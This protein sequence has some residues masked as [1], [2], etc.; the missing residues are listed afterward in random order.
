V[1][2]DYV[3]ISGASRTGSTLLLKILNSNPDIA[4]CRENYFLGHQ[5][6]REGIRYAI[7]RNVGD[8]I[9]EASV[10]QLV[11]FMY[12]GEFKRS[13]QT[14]W[15]WLRAKTDRETFLQKMLAA[16]VRDDRTIFATM[17]EIHGDWLQQRKGLAKS[18]PVLGEKTPSHIYYVPT[19]LQWFPNSRVIHTFRDPRG[20]FASE[21]RVRRQ[22]PLSFPYKKLSRVGPALFGFV[23]LQVTYAWSRAARLHT[24]YKRLY[25]DSYRLL[26]FEDLVTTPRKSIERLC[27]FLD[28]RFCIKMMDQKVVGRG[29]RHGQ[30]GFDQ[31]AVHRWKETN[32]PWV[33]KWFHLWGRKTL[34]ELDYESIQ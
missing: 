9:D 20:I 18:H 17:L 13:T 28:V 11:D 31:T 27:D 30:P 16:P 33:N 1:K 25:P 23:L 10:R 26:R 19:L 21:L 12:D 4:I 29:F 15:K 7:K 22:Y 5:I 34:I 32:P 3:F 24:R 2:P 6:R 14:Y 8:L